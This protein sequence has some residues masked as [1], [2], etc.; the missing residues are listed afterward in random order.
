MRY[1]SHSGQ[2]QLDL[3]VEALE[4]PL[5]H[6]FAEDG[7]E[8][9]R[10]LGVPDEGRGL[11][12]RRRLRLELERV[13]GGEVVE[14]VLGATGVDQVRGDHRVVGCRD[15]QGLRVVHGKPDALAC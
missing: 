9:A 7:C 6:P 5:A 3:V 11:L 12:L 4:A 14:I 2:R 8:P 10:R 13:L 1:V 15:A